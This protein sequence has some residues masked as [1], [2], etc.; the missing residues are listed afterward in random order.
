MINKENIVRKIEHVL[1]N[2]YKFQSKETK[3]RNLFIDRFIKQ[4]FGP[5]KFY[6]SLKT[7]GCGSFGVDG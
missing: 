3:K 1:K 5:G 2:V 4:N 6:A 7:Y